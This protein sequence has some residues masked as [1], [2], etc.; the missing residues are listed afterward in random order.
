MAGLP[1]FGHFLIG[2]FL[3]SAFAVTST[4]LLFVITAEQ[5]QDSI[6]S[7][8]IGTAKTSIGA[9]RQDVAKV[10]NYYA[11][12]DLFTKKQVDT[13]LQLYQANI[14]RQ[15]K[16]VQ[17]VNASARV[18]GAINQSDT[19]AVISPLKLHPFTETATSPTDRAQVFD[20]SVAAYF[21][22]YY[23]TLDS[24]E[25]GPQRAA[26]VKARTR[27][28]GFKT[29]VYRLLAAYTNDLAAYH[30]ADSTV[31]SL[32]TQAATLQKMKKEFDDSVGAPGT[33]LNNDNYWDLCEDFYSFK[34][35][36]G[37]AAY[38]VV[39][40]P[41]MMLV[42]MLSIFMGVLGSLIGISRDFLHNPDGQTFWV[43]L[44]RIGLGA[45]VAFALFFFAA[46][47]MMAFGQE[48]SAAGG[49]TQLSPYLISFLGI[50]AGY[51][52]DHVTAW[53]CEVG[54]RM[55]ALTTGAEPDRWAIRLAAVT[56]ERNLT[57]PALAKAIGVPVED[58]VAW[59]ALTRPV[60]SESQKALSLYLHTDRSLL[61]TD[62][63]PERA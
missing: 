40:L 41:K 62:L 63:E 33:P 37:D 61:F 39:L 16:L 54:Q 58:V 2:L 12:L 6:A 4:I 44:F 9:I 38:K 24:L 15:A 45:G 51:L 57:P 14:A 30:A 47:G 3:V 10:E 20:E 59:T 35:L 46:A 5:L 26:A 22:P 7:T 48:A 25:N 27:L 23:A 53:M 8:D 1:K 31:Q 50:T 21:A 32:Q 55:F 28:D 34:S 18:R 11:M 43:I 13:Q 52:S 42:L 29:E 19:D 60:P 56:Q 49:Q 36:V 17:L